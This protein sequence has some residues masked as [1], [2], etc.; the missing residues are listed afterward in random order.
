[1][2]VLKGQH[3]GHGHMTKTSDMA[4]LR[5]RKKR[6]LLVFLI[7]FFFWL[8]YMLSSLPSIRKDLTGTEDVQDVDK[9]VS[10]KHFTTAEHDRREEKIDPAK[11]VIAAPHLPPGDG[12]EDVREQP[13]TSTNGS[14]SEDVKNIDAGDKHVDV[15]A[16]GSFIKNKTYELGVKLKN[17]TLEVGEKVKNKTLEQLGMMG[18]VAPHKISQLVFVPTKWNLT[19]SFEDIGDIMKE[20]QF[21]NKIDP[22]NLNGPILVSSRNRTANFTY[23]MPLKFGFC[24]CFEHYCVCCSKITNRRLH[25][26]VTACSN[27]TFVS[28]T[29]ELDLHF[30][31]DGKPVHQS[32]ISADQSPLLCLGSS[33][34]VADICVHFFNMTFKVNEHNAHQTQLLGCTDLSL[35]LYNR[36]IGAFPVDCF[37]IPGDPNQV[38]KDRKFNMMFNWVP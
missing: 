29:H 13:N 18:M 30:S 33:P 1:M 4:V 6:L 27:F 31:L 24:D 7:A 20:T 26:N 32:K 35:S 5:F 37:Q 11:N 9:S 16:I 21:L 8:M 19:V 22:L 23:N 14:K 38:H 15:L 10:R 12:S 2:M 3:S 34:R 17:K 28:K 25:L 36:T